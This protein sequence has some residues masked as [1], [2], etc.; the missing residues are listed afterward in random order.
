MQKPRTLLIAPGQRFGHLT[1]LREVALRRGRR[2]VECE[3]ECG[4]ILTTDAYKLAS[5]HTGSCGCVRRAKLAAWVNSPEN[6]ERIRELHRDPEWTARRLAASFTPEAVAKRAEA[7]RKHGLADHPLYGIWRGILDRCE[8]PRYRDYRHYGGRGIKVCA[9]WHDV[10][11]F[12]A[13]VEANLGPRPEGTSLDRWPDNGGN[14]EPGNVRWA[15]WK[16]QNNNRRSNSDITP[17]AADALNRLQR[18]TGMSRVDAIS[19]AV[20]FYERA[21]ATSEPAA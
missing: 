16:Q 11:V 2:R 17:E 20:L 6:A 9:E 1:V 18:R 7:A 14:Y 15:T 12:V 13:W 19:Q 3:C 5:G 10:A 4:T 8:N 21:D